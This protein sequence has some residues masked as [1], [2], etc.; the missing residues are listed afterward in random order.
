MVKFGLDITSFKM[1]HHL[2]LYNKVD[3]LLCMRPRWHPWGVEKDSILDHMVIYKIWS[4]EHKPIQMSHILSQ[5]TFTS[6]VTLTFDLR[7]WNIVYIRS[8]YE[9]N[10]LQKYEWSKSARRPRRSLRTDKH[11][12]IQTGW[13]YQYYNRDTL[14][15]AQNHPIVLKTTKW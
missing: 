12:N 7:S 13:G 1:S 4:R 11:T 14:H 8:G 2:S 5:V 6:V 15:L 3:F 10:I 9:L